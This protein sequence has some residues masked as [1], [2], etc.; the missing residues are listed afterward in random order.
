VRRANKKRTSQKKTFS[1]QTQSVI[2]L[3]KLQKNVKKKKRGL[4]MSGV[5]ATSS[6]TKDG[7]AIFGEAIFEEAIFEEAIFEE[8]TQKQ[9]EPGQCPECA[10]RSG[11]MT[12][13]MSHCKRVLVPATGTDV[14]V[15]CTNEVSSSGVRR[16]RGCSAK[17]GECTSCARPFRELAAYRQSVVAYHQQSLDELRREEMWSRKFHQ[18]KQERAQ[19][20]RA[21]GVTLDREQLRLAE[22][23]AQDDL[24]TRWSSDPTFVRNS[25]YMP[26]ETCLALQSEAVSKLRAADRIFS[27]HALPPQQVTRFREMWNESFSHEHKRAEET[28]S[29]VLDD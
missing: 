19:A 12:C 17:F 10:S 21:A 23:A 4:A 3:L 18:A 13:D 14:A 24:E 9:Y 6:E 27:I 25:R 26:L 5:P 20:R 28:S 15:V 1:H 16:C 11:V 8:A 22:N 2:F 7:E 29:I